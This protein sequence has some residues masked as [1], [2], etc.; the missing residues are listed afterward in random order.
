[1][2]PFPPSPRCPRPRMEPPT[3]SRGEDAATVPSA[4]RSSHMP[5]QPPA[6]HLPLSGRCWKWVHCGTCRWG[7]GKAATSTPCL[8][9]TLDRGSRDSQRSK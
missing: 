4:V 3:T 6:L 2:H 5:G 8:R 9:R 1:M 7:I